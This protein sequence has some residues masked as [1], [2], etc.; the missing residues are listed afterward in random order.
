[1]K[2]LMFFSFILF[3]Y[4]VFEARPVLA[5]DQVTNEKTIPLVSKKSDP[6]VLRIDKDKA[7]WILD[8]SNLTI[9]K[10]SKEGKTE[11]TFKSGK[12]KQDLFRDPVDFIFAED[13]SLVVVDPGFERV[14]YIEK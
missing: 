13:G 11:A 10:I 9:Q 3:F 2:K 1:M 14:V 5:Y 4:V 12:K 7:L 8:R 6:T